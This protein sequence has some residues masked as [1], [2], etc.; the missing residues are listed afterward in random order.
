MR[1]PAPDPTAHGTRLATGLSALAGILLAA[2]LVIAVLDLPRDAAGLAA[3]AERYIP[4]SG[5]THPVTAVLLNFRLYDT[6]LELGV[7]LLAVLGTLLFQP[8][9][10]LRAITRMPEPEPVMQWLIRLL[11]P[12]IV[13]SSGYLLWAGKHAPGGAFQAGVVLGAGFLLL[14]LVGQR[15][16]TDLSGPLFRGLLALGFGVFLAVGFGSLLLADNLFTLPPHQAGNLILL[17]E[18]AATI[19]IGITVSALILGLQPR[20]ATRLTT[21]ADTPQ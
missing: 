20:L 2:L 18:A 6:W 4:E 9:S 15:S 11:F 1:S 8:H 10:D 17:M 5:V 7:L 13:L 3:L 12:L 21:S 16:I 14:W 19:S